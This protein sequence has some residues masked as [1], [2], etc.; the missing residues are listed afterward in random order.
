M[1]KE[2]LSITY[3]IAL[4][5]SNV[6]A[7]RIGLIGP[8]SVAG[9]PLAYITCFFVCDIVHEKYGTK[10]AK[11]LVNYGFASVLLSLAFIYICYLIPAADKT[12]N[13]AFKS[14][15]NNSWRVLVASLTA[16]MISNHSDIA[17]FNFIGKKGGN[18]L[19]RK[20]LSTFISQ[21]LDSSVFCTLA[22][23]GIMPLKS[24]LVLIFSE[25]TIKFIVNCLDMPFYA[26]CV[27][28]KMK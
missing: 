25:Y 5:M 14:V 16:Y 6:T 27:K 3:V 23:A 26:F 19:I 22:F 11:K 17:M 28:G 24:L 20:S 1:S 15:F 4:I 8:L 2:L 9:N 7:N 10:E 13:E 12:F 18:F 21:L